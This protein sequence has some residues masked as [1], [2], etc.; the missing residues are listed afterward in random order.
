MTLQ[1]F[2]AVSLDLHLPDGHASTLFH[3]LRSNP[4]YKDIPVLIASVDEPADPS[5]YD[6]FKGVSW[7]AKPLLA[8]RLVTT[9]NKLTQ[10]S[11]QC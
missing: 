6:D 7:L 3:E 5:L 11:H 9:I 8:E 4:R 1:A 10:H 2:V